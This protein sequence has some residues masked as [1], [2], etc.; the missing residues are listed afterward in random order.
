M[1]T[2]LSDIDQVLIRYGDTLSPEQLSFKVEGSLTP[3]QC[4]T[5]LTHLLSSPDWLTSAYQDQMVTMKMRLAIINLEE[6]PKTARTA[7]VLIS[8]LE[9]LGNRLDKRVE[10][11]E[12]DL[13]QLYAFQ[14]AVLLDAV[15][16]TLAHMREEL[17]G[18]K[19]GKIKIPEKAWDKALENGLRFAQMEI[20]RHEATEDDDEVEADDEWEE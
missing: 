16:A 20:S 5:R 18:E 2:K 10:A 19:D 15:N 1:P 9:K 14:G 4:A 17:T 11:T 7:E 6:M 13:S 12:K 8:A 3:E